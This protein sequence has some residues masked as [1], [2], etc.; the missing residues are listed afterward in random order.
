AAHRPTRGSTPAPDDARRARGAPLTP[1]APGPRRA[2]IHGFRPLS[3]PARPPGIKIPGYTN[4]VLRTASRSPA[5]A[6]VRKTPPSST[7]GS[8]QVF[9]G[10]AGGSTPGR[11]GRAGHGSEAGDERPAGLGSVG[12]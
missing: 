8:R 6:F 12:C 1:N 3:C 7:G 11:A 5:T 2:L 10:V 4:E 9:V